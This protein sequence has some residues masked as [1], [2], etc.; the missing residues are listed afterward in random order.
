MRFF[1]VV[2]EGVGIAVK[3]DSGTVTGFFTTR[4]VFAADSESAIEKA[5]LSILEEWARTEGLGKG[6]ESAPNFRVDLVEQIGLW[7][8]LFGGIPNAGFT[9]YEQ[10]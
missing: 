10:D 3:C 8:Y 1:R 9:F 5:K 7:R 6:N 2:L 4:T